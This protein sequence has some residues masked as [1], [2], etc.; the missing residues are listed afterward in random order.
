MAYIYEILNT[1]NDKVYVGKTEFSLEKRFSEHCREA[2]KVRCEKRPLY[3]AMRKYGVD[4]FYIKLIEETDCPEEREVFWIDQRQSYHKGYN[5]T[6]GGDGKKYL[7]YDKI[8][9]TYTILNNIE[10]TAKEFGIH[11]K[12]VSKILQAND[13]HTISGQ[14]ASLN[15]LG[16]A[17]EQYDLAGN[18]LGTFQSV[19]AA[20]KA[21]GKIAGRGG[22]GGPTGHISAACRG[23]RKTAYGYVWK[24]TE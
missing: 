8:I 21:I 13:V 14:E 3:A 10:D 5:A 20:A 18:Y 24:Y 12:T 7:D 22:S 17:V 1:M 2:L 15:K 16:R 9:A 23:D 11:R 19:K 4:K 6:H